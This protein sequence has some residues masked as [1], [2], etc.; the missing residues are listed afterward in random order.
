R[1]CEYHKSGL[2]VASNQGAVVVRNIV[3]EYST[4]VRRDGPCHL[5]AEILEHKRNAF[6]GI[7]GQPLFNLELSLFEEKLCDRV[8]PGVDGLESLPDSVEEFERT[9]L[10]FSDKRRE[11]EAVVLIVFSR[12]ARQTNRFAGCE[13]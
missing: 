13:G 6:E 9:D 8:D 11:P 3:L 5:L 2:L 4:T 7:A 10:T 1:L 12:Q